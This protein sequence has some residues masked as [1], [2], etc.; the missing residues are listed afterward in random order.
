[1]L[2]L[3]LEK[4]IDRKAEYYLTSYSFLLLISYNYYWFDPCS[5]R[6]KFT[7]LQWGTGLGHT[8][9]D[10]DF[11]DHQGKN[12]GTGREISVTFEW[13]ASVFWEGRIHHRNHWSV[14]WK[15]RVIHF[16]CHSNPLDCGRSSCPKRLILIEH[17][18]GKPV[19]L[20]YGNL[21][22]V[23]ADHFRAWFGF[24]AKPV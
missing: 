7:E 20:G 17:Q 8:H 11:G 21:P 14:G 2:R 9:L 3:V 19:C 10:V 12:H 16:P 24:D 6:G 4:K 18:D 13:G 23:G 5:W 22:Q 15:N 1:M